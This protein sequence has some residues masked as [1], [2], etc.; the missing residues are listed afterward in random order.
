MEMET[1]HRRVC[2]L[3]I[4]KRGNDSVT[5]AQI[6]HRHTHTHTDTHRHTQTHTDTDTIVFMI[7]DSNTDS[8][9]HSA[10]LYCSQS[11]QRAL[12]WPVR[13]SA[14]LYCSRSSEGAFCCGVWV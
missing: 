2:A 10:G 6:N 11:G 5:A 12:C 4:R 7:R 3:F 13:V 8:I 9:T 14:G 1:R